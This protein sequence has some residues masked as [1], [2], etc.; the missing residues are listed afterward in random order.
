M[1]D[2]TFLHPMF[3]PPFS[4]TPF[5]EELQSDVQLAALYFINPEEFVNVLTY[6]QYCQLDCTDE[7]GQENVQIIIFYCAVDY[8]RAEAYAH[9]CKFVY[10]ARW[11]D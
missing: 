11:L 3:R 10:Q 1:V 6:C 5:P 9:H 4:P 8:G 7:A 2:V